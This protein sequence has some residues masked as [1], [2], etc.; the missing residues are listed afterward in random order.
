[1]D[2]ELY[3]KAPLYKSHQKYG[4]QEPLVFFTPSIG[5][6]AIQYIDNNFFGENNFNVIFG[7]KGS[8]K[9]A[10]DEK[11]LYLFN[12]LNKSKKKVFRGE[13][14]RDILVLEEK[15]MIIFTGETTG[16]IAILQNKK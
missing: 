11:S 16:I 12:S 14:V 4:F 1:M 2:S 3:K 9:D 8:N 6:S 13:R 5:I 15:S 10:L 7:S